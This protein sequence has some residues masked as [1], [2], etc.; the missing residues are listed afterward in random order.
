VKAL[1]YGNGR[2]VGRQADRPS[3][4]RSDSQLGKRDSPKMKALG[5]K[6][7]EIIWAPAQQCPCQPPKKTKAQLFAAVGCFAT[8]HKAISTRAGNL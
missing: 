6:D 2:P 5:G 1:E 3:V 8:A 7:P 4:L